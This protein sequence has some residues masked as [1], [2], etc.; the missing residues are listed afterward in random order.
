MHFQFSVE[1]QGHERFIGRRIENFSWHIWACMLS[2]TL[3]VWFCGPIS[4]FGVYYREWLAPA[5][6]SRRYVI[7]SEN[8]IEAKINLNG[9]SSVTVVY[10][11][12]GMQIVCAIVS[13]LCFVL[14]ETP[15]NAEYIETIIFHESV[16]VVSLIN[17][18]NVLL[19]WVEF[20]MTVVFDKYLT[21][22][23]WF[24]LFFSLN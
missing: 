16:D 24:V 22:F 11:S 8:W 12:Q 1:F 14:R 9:F 20:W 3:G 19:K 13:T 23:F 5:F 6:T 2:S 15:G 4:G 10:D 17:N 7:V 21:S 18:G